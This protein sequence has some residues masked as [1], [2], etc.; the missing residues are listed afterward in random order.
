MSIPTNISEK[1]IWFNKLLDPADNCKNLRAFCLNIFDCK[2]EKNQYWAL[3]DMLDPKVRLI[4]Y[5][6]ARQ[7]GKTQVIA[8]Y[9]V[10]AAL[11]PEFVIIEY[12]GRANAYI[13]APK[14]EQAEIS[15]ERFSNFVHF[16]KYNVFSDSII[17][18][19]FD[20]MTFR[21]GFEVRAITASRNA[22]VEGLTT[23]IQTLDESQAISPY[24]ARE[25]LTGDTVIPLPNGSFS[26]LKDVVEKRLK[27]I[28]P[29]GPE[30]PL[31]Y[32][33]Y[34]E[35]TIYE[36]KLTNGDTLRCNK[37]HRHLVY[38]YD[39]NWT[40]S[41]IRK[42]IT[43][44]LTTSDRIAVP[45]S[46][47][48]FGNEG[49]YIE[50]FLIG[51]FLGDGYMSDKSAPSLCCS[52]KLVNYLY[53]SIYK[54]Y[55]LK[56]RVKKIQKTKKAVE[57][58]FLNNTNKKKNKLIQYF[59]SIGIWN[60]T[61]VN[62]TIP[63][64]EWS[65][66]FLKGL[67]SG[68]IE[69][70]GTIYLSKSKAQSSIT[71]NNISKKL[72]TQLKFYLLKFGIHCT[73]HEDKRNK[74]ICYILRISKIEDVIKFY[75]NIKLY[76]KQ[77]KLKKV[78]EKIKNKK[79]KH[80]SNFYPKT[81][82]FVKIKSIKKLKNKEKVY[83]V[84][85]KNP[86]LWIANNI[87]TLNSLFPMGGGVPHGAK[88]I[89][90]GVPGLLGSHFHK[91]Y[92]NK[93][94]SQTNPLG[95]VHHVYPYQDCPRLA[96]DYVLR[97]KN[98]DPDSFERNYELKWERSNYGYFTT[99]EEYEACEEDYDVHEM[100]KKAIENNWPMYWGI[101]F[102][103]LRDSTVLTTIAQNPVN[104]HY[105]LV[106]DIIEFQGT[107]YIDQIGYIKNIYVPGHIK[108]TC[109]D[110][111]GVGEMPIEVLN[112]G[113]ILTTGINF[114]LQSKDKI[115][116]NLRY[117]IQNKLIHWPKKLPNKEYRKFKQEFLE[118]EIE[119]KVT[120]LISVHH[121]LDDNLARDDYADSLC[122]AIWAAAEYVEPNISFI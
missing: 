82:R 91:A 72:I 24:K 12:P 61:G 51:L 30:K 86:N 35:D 28:T 41:R 43:T 71:F 97:L 29:N 69:T 17:A 67:I 83:C 111:S 78:I 65:R 57:G 22:E 16:N 119:H 47:P 3:R 80:K 36:I 52:K 104:E 6:S 31:K 76:T 39:W 116:K 81:M 74:K 21:N 25:C 118:L 58:F 53:K 107:E 48:Y 94:D 85:L 42:I 66:P 20:K 38:N 13:F 60:F 75:Y 89:Q 14:K 18:D 79:G 113:G 73:I 49:D 98:E 96:M 37:N 87:V 115:Y 1:A 7:G 45:N 10:I 121:N 90:T 101:D 44:D 68:L 2:L 26:T 110:K 93:F 33:K 102:A 8:L 32:F 103:K 117:Q 120:G 122:L 19:K 50:G 63:N 88:I 54:R 106:G 59:K 105:Y 46:L 95:Y 9:H 55:N 112:D 34:D 77:K 64:K 40:N 114:S 70:D 56:L 109:A 11:F 4:Y 27:I 23:H 92:K 99:Y 15:F 84:R 108:H 100:Y 5:S 62:K